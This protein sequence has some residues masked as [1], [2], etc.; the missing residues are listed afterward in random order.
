MY[1][2]SYA[3]IDKTLSTLSQLNVTLNTL[4]VK[5]VGKALSKT[6]KQKGVSV[7]AN[8]KVVKNAERV[9]LLQVKFVESEGD[10]HVELV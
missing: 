8:G 9:N 5:A 7:A 1:I 6:F 10:A 2:S 3:Q 4:L